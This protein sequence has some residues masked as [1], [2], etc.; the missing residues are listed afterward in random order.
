MEQI[1][2]YHKD[3]S[4]ELINDPVLFSTIKQA[5]HRKVLLG[6]DVITMTVEAATARNF[7]VG[8]YI[9]LFGMPRYTINQ[10]PGVQKLATADMSTI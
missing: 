1:L 4:S 7:G 3:G 10:I 9:Q 8:D 2:I 5:E 6:E